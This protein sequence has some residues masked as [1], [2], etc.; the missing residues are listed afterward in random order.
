MEGVN[1][2]EKDGLKNYLNRIWNPTLTLIGVDGVPPSERAGNVLRPFTTLTFSL[3][4]PP[5]LNPEKA[6][7]CVKE[8]LLE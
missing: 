1:K 7:T 4:L 5:T 6:L 3:R 8:Y 2:V